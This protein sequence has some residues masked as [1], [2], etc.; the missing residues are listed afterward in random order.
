MCSNGQT[1][2]ADTA[3]DAHFSCGLLLLIT[4]AACARAWR[5]QRCGAAV[6]Y[7]ERRCLAGFGVRQHSEWLL[8]P[9]SKNTSLQVQAAMTLDTPWASSPTQTHITAH[10]P[11]THN[12]V[13]ECLA[14]RKA[15][16]RQVQRIPVA[17]ALPQHTLRRP[18]LEIG[19]GSEPIAN[20]GSSQDVTNW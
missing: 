5:Q 12:R 4:G 15:C 11:T 19:F 17:R 9:P 10:T 8:Y 16:G 1:S 14:V 3:P 18:A 20:H 6:A 2:P 7:G 13:S